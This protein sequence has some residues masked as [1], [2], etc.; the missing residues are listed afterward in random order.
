VTFYHIFRHLF[1][2][3]YR[4]IID[5]I[6]ECEDATSLIQALEKL[7]LGVNYSKT[8]L[9]SRNENHIFE[10]LHRWPSLQLGAEETTAEDIQTYIDEQI[11]K[12]IMN[13]PVLKSYATQLEDHLRRTT[14]V[15]FLYARLTCETIREA[16]PS[17][18]A[19]VTEIIDSLN[20]RLSTLD[21]LYDNYLLQRLSSNNLY[22]NQ[23]ALRT[24]QW[25][26]CSPSPV[27]STF[28]FRALALDLKNDRT[29]SS[30]SLDLSIKSTIS[31]SLGVLV[32]WQETGTF[33]YATLMH[34]SLR[35]YLSRLAHNPPQW[36]ALSVPFNSIVHESAHLALLSACC[37]ITSTPVVWSHL[38]GFHDSGDRRRK[39]SENRPKSLRRQLAKEQPWYL[40]EQRQRLDLELHRVWRKKVA[41][42][43]QSELADIPDDLDLGSLEWVK[44]RRK[45]LH[46]I[47]TL[48]SQSAVEVH[49]LV[50]V[51]SMRERD[52]MIYSFE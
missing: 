13:R 8:L 24:L 25:I 18:Q 46:L 41:K 22:R 12:L 17:T 3:S 34:H 30:D 42:S 19:Q 33:C 36:E 26:K 16:D 11:R 32:E 45:Q 4:F 7:E 29:I 14:G 6:D 51:T 49:Q 40:W 50:G 52:L 5:G 37:I 35:D 28:L 47:Q 44:N 27:T 23:V 10:Q 31:K 21:A 20:G 43:V 39:L 15:M 1:L 48:E 2:I 38:Q 9:I